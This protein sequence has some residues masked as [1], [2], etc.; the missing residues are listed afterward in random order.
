[1]KQTKK[2]QRKKDLNLKSLKK[3]KELKEEL[4]FEKYIFRVVVG[5]A[6][7]FLLPLVLDGFLG[8]VFSLL[9]GFIAIKSTLN[10]T[11]LFRIEDKIEKEREKLI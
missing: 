7:L 11:G 6:L 10:A 1:M 8:I 3:I 9:I 4:I 2:T 5:I